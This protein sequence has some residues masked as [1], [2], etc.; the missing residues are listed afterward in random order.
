MKLALFVLCTLFAAAHAETIPV[1]RMLRLS[2]L[3]DQ[4]TS[5]DGKMIAMVVERPIDKLERYDREYN[6]AHRGSVFIAGGPFATT[7]ELPLNPAHILALWFPQ[8]SPDSKHLLLMADVGDRITPWVFDIDTRILHELTQRSVSY[9]LVQPVWLTSSEV[10]CALLPPNSASALLYSRA[11][12][13][14]RAREEGK[15]ALGKEPTA[16]VDDASD[17]AEAGEDE[18]VSINV[19]TGQGKKLFAG[20]SLRMVPGRSNGP[21][22]VLEELG[23]TAGVSLGN[24]VHSIDPAGGLRY[25]LVIVRADGSALPIMAKVIDPYPCL[26]DIPISPDGNDAIVPGKVEADSASAGLHLFH[27]DLERGTATD[28]QNGSLQLSVGVVEDHGCKIPAIWSPSGRL[29]LK[30]RDKR[31]D[32]SRLD[33]WLIREGREPANLTKQMDTVPSVLYPGPDRESILGIEKDTA[34]TINLESMQVNQV[35]IPSDEAIE[36]VIWPKPLLSLYSLGVFEMKVPRSIGQEA[37]Q[38][39]VYSGLNK[40]TRDIYQLDVSSGATVKSGHLGA[41]IEI[42][43][44]SD[45]G[46]RL[47]LLDRSHDPVFRVSELS[48]PGAVSKTLLEENTGIPELARPQCRMISYRSLDGEKLQAEILLPEDYDGKTL[49]PA[50][51]GVYPGD[52]YHGSEHCSVEI[53]GQAASQG[54]LSNYW[55]LFSLHGFAVIF[56]S[57]PTEASRM[58][59]DPM[60]SLASGVLPAIDQAVALGLVD[61]SRVGLVGHS[62]GGFAVYGLLTL[63][64]QFRCAIAQAGASD[65]ISIYGN[66]DAPNPFVLHNGAFW[67]ESGQA[68]LGAPPWEVEEQYARSSPLLYADRI[69]TPL[70]IIQGDEDYV[71]VQQGEE[72]YTALV[73]ERRKVVFVRYIGEGHGLLSPANIVDVWERMYKWFDGCLKVDVAS[74]KSNQ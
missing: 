26:E 1:E 38:K 3:Y 63:T 71:P 62:F 61:P 16:V 68:D 30:G 29:L 13:E 40:G 15:F 56:P 65:L 67:D 43:A 37:T 32:R 54:V 6:D 53:S 46:E 44:Y 7:Y 20:R 33:W 12:H 59:H 35:K 60:S 42:L 69:K 28:L 64:S 2:A 9:P 18:L 50:V 49:L 31:D 8:W 25:R 73:R 58:N 21:L 70:M 39:I 10:V 22:V 55:E 24:E 5:P 36:S 17:G 23:E 4:S 19:S 41:S 51:V 66:Q 57:M 45:R 11:W 14:R 72:M 34:W 48:F 74:A 47:F 52:I 27:L